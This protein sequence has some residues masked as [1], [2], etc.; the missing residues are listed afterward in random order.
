MD[1]KM[2]FLDSNPMIK[3]TCPFCKMSFKHEVYGGHEK[4][5]ETCECRADIRLDIKFE[6][7]IYARRQGIEG[8]VCAK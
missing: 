8:D 5:T 7:D 2:V 4:F 6:I 3:V 1:K